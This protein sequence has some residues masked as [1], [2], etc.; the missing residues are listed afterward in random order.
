VL[1]IEQLAA[2]T[3]PVLQEHLKLAE[4]VLAALGRDRKHD[5]F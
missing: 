3:V 5:R 4:A 2:A 1:A